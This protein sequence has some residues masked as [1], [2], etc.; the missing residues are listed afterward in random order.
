MSVSTKTQYLSHIHDN[1]ASLQYVGYRKQY[2]NI[3]LIGHLSYS[4]SIHLEEVAS[5]QA[6][7]EP[8]AIRILDPR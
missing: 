2:D 5:H 8:P 4:C 3:G 7:G 6:H 1:K